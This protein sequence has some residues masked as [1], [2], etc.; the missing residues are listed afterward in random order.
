[1]KVRCNGGP[2]RCVGLVPPAQSGVVVVR[3]GIDDHVLF[4]AMRQ[5]Q[6]RAAVAEAEL[7]DSHA[8]HAEAL[9]HSLDLRSDD[10]Q[11]FRN[12][13]Q[14]AEFRI[15]MRKQFGPQRLHPRA[16]N[17]SLIFRGDGP[18]GFEA[19]EVIEPQQIA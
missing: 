19:T 10:T 16:A 2:F 4:A 12:Q 5:M 11:V 7:H 6:M 8:G 3:A 1:M 14:V 9:S 13:R 17:R 15:Q 18:V